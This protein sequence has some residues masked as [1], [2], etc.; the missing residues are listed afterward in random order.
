M[1]ERFHPVGEG[2][3]ER[4]GYSDCPT[5]KAFDDSDSHR[6]MVNMTERSG[7]HNSVPADGRAAAV[8][9]IALRRKETCGSGW[10]WVQ[11]YLRH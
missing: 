9:Q 10:H 2:Q 6:E 11:Q 3:K 4:N 8:R 1:G 7:F 5:V